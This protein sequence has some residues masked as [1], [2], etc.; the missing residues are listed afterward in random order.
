VAVVNRNNNR[1]NRML[2]YSNE[3]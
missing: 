3:L 1:T 2:P